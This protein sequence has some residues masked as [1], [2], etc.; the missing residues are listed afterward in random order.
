MKSSRNNVRDDY[1]AG[2]ALPEPVK[3]LKAPT[4]ALR[5]SKET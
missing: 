2:L 1:N 5:I 4:A 3:G